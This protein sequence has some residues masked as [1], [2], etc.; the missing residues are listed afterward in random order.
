M[1]RSIA[2][3]DATFYWVPMGLDEIG[4]KKGQVAIRRIIDEVED[5]EVESAR[6]GWRAG[7]TKPFRRPLA[8]W[9]LNRPRNPTGSGTT[10]CKGGSSNDLEQIGVI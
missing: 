8:S 9:A 1:K 2:G 6:N 7:R 4:W 10:S 5:C 3:E